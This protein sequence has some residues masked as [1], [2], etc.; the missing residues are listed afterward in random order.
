MTNKIK[1][2]AKKKRN[3]GLIKGRTNMKEHLPASAGCLP[4]QT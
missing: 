4:E 3:A 1:N 2:P